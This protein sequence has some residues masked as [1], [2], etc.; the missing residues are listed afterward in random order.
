[1]FEPSNN[2][3][4]QVVDLAA[5][6]QRPISSEP[7]AIPMRQ[8]A[9]DA[10]PMPPLTAEPPLGRWRT[11][12]RLIKAGA[13]RGQR[14]AT[15]AYNAPEARLV[16]LQEAVSV[17]ERNLATARTSVARGSASRGL[18]LQLARRLHQAREELSIFLSPLA[19]PGIAARR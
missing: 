7:I 4:R 9:E 14:G 11:N 17:H 8:S 13:R 1:M 12:K 6:S 16:K 10:S 15:C 18:L 3:H 2:A 19:K 5:W